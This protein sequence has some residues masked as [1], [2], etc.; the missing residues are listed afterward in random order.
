[1]PAPPTPRVD[2]KLVPARVDGA[3]AGASEHWHEPF[4]G[5][6]LVW[7]NVQ[8]VERLNSWIRERERSIIE[9]LR[10]DDESLTHMPFLAV[11]PNPTVSFNVHHHTS[12][13]DGGFVFGGSLH[14]HRDNANGGFAYAVYHP[15]TALPKLAFERLE[16]TPVP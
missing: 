7:N 10:D 11:P 1:M 8:L 2:G 5:G 4:S 6:E 12:E 16:V 15:G 3:Q 14:D 13:F 9:N